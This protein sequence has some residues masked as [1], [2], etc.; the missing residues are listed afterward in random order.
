MNDADI[1]FL[2]YAMTQGRSNLTDE[3]K[4][5]L[6]TMASHHLRRSDPVEVSLYPVAP[7]AGGATVTVP[8]TIQSVR[9]DGMVK[10]KLDEAI[11]RPSDGMFVETDTI[12]VQRGQIFPPTPEPAP[13]PVPDPAPTSAA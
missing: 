5:R 12:V 8:G 3:E 10:V 1:A 6:A 7:G 9:D 2:A 13:E 4:A 11:E